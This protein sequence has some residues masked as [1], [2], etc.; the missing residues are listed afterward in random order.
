MKPIDNTLA[1]ATRDIV[2]A[3]LPQGFAVE[4]NAPETLEDCSTYMAIHGR[5]CVSNWFGPESIFGQPCDHYAFSAWHDYRHITTQGSFDRCGERVVN[6]AMLNDL[7][8]WWHRTECTLR[9]YNRAAACIKA[10]NLGRLD[11][12]HSFGDAPPNAR[13]FTTGYLSALGILVEG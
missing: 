4:S 11:Y 10:H 12:W 8:A 9:D 13:L 3:L 7:C 6:T 1:R 2:A 5:P